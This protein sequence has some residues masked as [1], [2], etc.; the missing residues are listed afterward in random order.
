M[1]TASNAERSAVREEVRKIVREM[2]VSGE[3]KGGKDQNELSDH[4]AAVVSLSVSEQRNPPRNTSVESTSPALETSVGASKPD[5]LAGNMVPI[6]QN[7]QAQ[8]RK[9]LFVDLLSTQSSD[10]TNDPESPITSKVG[11]EPGHQ[12]KLAENK[13]MTPSEIHPDPDTR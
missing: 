2:V 5:T 12:R 7:S 3:L 13:V 6:T 11:E 1:D 9:A 10:D 4:D 8:N